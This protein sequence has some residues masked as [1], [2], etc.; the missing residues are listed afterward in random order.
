MTTKFDAKIR[1]KNENLN[2]DDTKIER[3]FELHLDSHREHER[4]RS[5]AGR[6]D[7]ER[8]DAMDER[9]LENE[10]Q[11]TIERYGGNRYRERNTREGDSNREPEHQLG[12]V[13]TR[14]DV[15][16]DLVRRNVAARSGSN[17]FPTSRRLDQNRDSVREGTRGRGEETERMNPMK[18]ERRGDTTHVSAVS[19]IVRT[20]AEHRLRNKNPHF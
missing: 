13:R 4:K 18:N 9:Q 8:V 17:N 19:D 12:N 6:R 2:S 5:V 1:S 10:D 3:N 11:R 15:V 7:I 16:S 14:L 20:R